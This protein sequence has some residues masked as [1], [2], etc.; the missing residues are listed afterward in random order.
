MHIAD[1]WKEKNE[2]LMNH[3]DLFK[4]WDL[5]DIIIVRKMIIMKVMEIPLEGLTFFFKKRF[6]A[7]RFCPE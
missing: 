2:L 5:H 1:Y 7:E 6:M 4:D 3:G